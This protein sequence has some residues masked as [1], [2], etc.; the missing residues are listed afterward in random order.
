M[1][2]LPLE[3]EWN[4]IL[5]KL[6]KVE[7]ESLLVIA[8]TFLNLKQENEP[9]TLEQYNKE[10]DES[11]MAMDKGESISHEEVIRQSKTWFNGK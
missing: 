8:R 9:V 7:R 10:I 4:E 6:S 2:A 1:G 3:N 11:M 5:P